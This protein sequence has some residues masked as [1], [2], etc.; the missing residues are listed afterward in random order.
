MRGKIRTDLTGQ[1]F[2][3]WTVLRP[4]PM[5]PNRN[6]KWLCRCDCG[7]EKE[8]WTNS[9]TSGQSKGCPQCAGKMRRTRPGT[10]AEI[11]E[12][13]RSGMTA[14]EIAKAMR[15]ALPTVN[16]YLYG[17]LRNLLTRYQQEESTNGELAQG[18]AGGGTDAD[19]PAT[20][21]TAGRFTL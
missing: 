20:A 4:L 18:L 1:V 19:H 6:Y 14:R 16:N 9:L 5:S 12:L 13:R 8:V 10:M 2:G 17:G 15:L 21:G 11:M 3:R 7:K